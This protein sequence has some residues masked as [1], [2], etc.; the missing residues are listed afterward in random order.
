[1]R[2]IMENSRETYFILQHFV[3]KI[4]LFEEFRLKLRELRTP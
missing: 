1:M 3:P 4:K 2:L